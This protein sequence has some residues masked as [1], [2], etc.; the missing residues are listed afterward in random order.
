MSVNKLG[1]FKALCF[2]WREK[3]GLLDWS[4]TI[5]LSRLPKDTQAETT[6]YTEARTA[7]ISL[8]KDNSEDLSL[9]AKHE[10]IHLLIADLSY[11]AEERFVS[12][13]EIQ[14]ANEILVMKLENLIT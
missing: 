6:Y 3:F 5:Q 13:R 10:L 7:T 1:A 14:V 12:L 9:I 4:I 2:Q 8:N 11:L